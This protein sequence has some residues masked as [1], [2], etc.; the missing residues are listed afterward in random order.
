MEQ[1]LEL[2]SL[3]YKYD[4]LQFKDDVIQGLNACIRD[5]WDISSERLRPDWPEFVSN[6]IDVAAKNNGGDY[7]VELIPTLAEMWSDGRR[8]EADCSGIVALLDSNPSLSTAVAT[9]YQ[10]KLFTTEQN[11]KSRVKSVLDLFRDPAEN[12]DSWL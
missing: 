4:C 3:V 1:Y 6:H 9:Y 5:Y 12:E 11:V 10:D 2:Y 7:P 8:R